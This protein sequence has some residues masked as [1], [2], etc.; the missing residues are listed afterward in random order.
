MP[1]VRERPADL[2]ILTEKIKTAKGEKT[3]IV[4]KRQEKN[5]QSILKKYGF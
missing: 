4:E 3:L 2:E 1:A 5:I